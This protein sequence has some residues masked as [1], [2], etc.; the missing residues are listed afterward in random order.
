MYQ[1]L[2]DAWRLERSSFKLQRLAEDFYQRLVNYVASLSS[3]L[4]AKPSLAKKATLAELNIVKALAR[5]LLSLRLRKALIQALE[6][7][8]P[9]PSLTREEAEAVLA[10]LKALSKAE[11]ALNQQLSL[12]E[13]PRPRLVRLLRRV[14]EEL[15]P[16]LSPLEAESLAL[17]PP[18]I[19]EKLASEG[20]A[21]VIG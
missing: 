19:A 4:E 20:Y 12:G 11:E 10:A 14:P 16:G 6:N 5:D 15:A 17:L 1:E 8:D 7:G 21:I 3:S 2:K 18:N 13:K 9:F